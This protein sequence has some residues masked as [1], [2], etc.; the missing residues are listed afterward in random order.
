MKLFFIILQRNTSNSFEV[1]VSITFS[2][3]NLQGR[4]IYPDLTLQSRTTATGS[5]SP[6]STAELRLTFTKYNVRCPD[7][8]KEY[9]CRMRGVDSNSNSISEQDAESDPVKLDYRVQPY[10]IQIPRVRILGELF[11]TNERQF[12]VGTAVQLT[13]TGQIGSDPSATIRWCAK[14]AGAPSFTG[15]PQ[16]PTH[17]QS[18]QSGCQYTRTSS[19]N[20]NLT[21]SDTYIQFLCES[22]YS[23]LCETGT[24]RQYLNITLGSSELQQRVSNACSRD[25]SF[26]IPVLGSISAVLF[27]ICTGL[28]IFIIFRIQYYEKATCCYRRTEKKEYVMH[29]VTKVDNHQYQ[30]LGS[31]QKKHQ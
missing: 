3:D 1:S 17:S 15:L 30:D 26:L 5:L 4:I 7:D 22:G 9:R 27:V 6:V 25:L 31:D 16:T 2:Q 21:T 20:Y 8:F 14:T 19:I 28:V 13:C 12:E 23:G 18:S 29:N 11:D 24:A 10:V